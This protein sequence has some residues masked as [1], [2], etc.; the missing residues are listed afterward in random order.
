MKTTRKTALITG[1]ASGLGF[2]FAVLL[3]KDNYNLILVDIDVE[4]LGIA[5]TNIRRI[6]TVHIK[7]II[8]DL[9]ETAS[10][11]AILREIGNTPIDVLIN[12]AG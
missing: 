11:E 2:E 4:K 8:Q 10:S 3:A 9:S 12:N 6:A 1:A 7:I 5:I